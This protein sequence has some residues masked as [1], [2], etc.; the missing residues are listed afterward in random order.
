MVQIGELFEQFFYWF[1]VQRKI[2]NGLC[3]APELQHDQIDMLSHCFKI[4]KALLYT[5]LINFFAWNVVPV[6]ELLTRCFDS[7]NSELT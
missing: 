6:L 7:L 2:N 3:L 4:F 1:I 5:L